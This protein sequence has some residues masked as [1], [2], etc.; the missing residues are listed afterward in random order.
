M[1]LPI[2]AIIL[3]YNE[4][5]NIE[6]CLK[7]IADWAS[8]VIIVDSFST[9]KTLEIVKKYTDK[10]H[11]RKFVNQA[12]QFNWALD[13][14]LINNDWI[15]RLDADEVMLM[16]TWEEIEGYFNIGSSEDRRS[17]EDKKFGPR[18]PDVNGFYMKRRVYFM[19]RWI[20]HGG[21]YP[22]WFLRLWRKD[23]GRYEERAMDEHV[24]LSKGKT[25][26]L[27]NDF[28]EHDHRNLNTWIEKHN[29][30]ATR[31]AH[32]YMRF[33]G[34]TQ[35]LTPAPEQSSVRGVAQNDAEKEGE[36]GE[37]VGKKRWYKENFYYKLPPFLRSLLYWKYRYFIRLGFLDG[38]PG[39]IFHFLQGFW[40]RFLVDSKIYELKRRS[41][42]KNF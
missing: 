29:S 39:L 13:N 14:V 22:A 24:I 23:A 31:E 9:D 36:L 41:T 38:I 3:T 6:N 1:K 11:Q 7:S 26:N 28:E 37:F 20:K 16:E 12:E 15:L 19:G 10:V 25:I 18:D 33:R 5:L 35:N 40:Y 34:T 4:A 30:Y 8:E 27:K 2:S 21:Y 32:E 42:K 17:S